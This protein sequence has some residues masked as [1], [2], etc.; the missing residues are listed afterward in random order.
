M[1]KTGERIIPEYDK[2]TLGFLEHINRYEFAKQFV[3]GKNVLDIACGSGYGTYELVN[4]GAKRIV[5]VDISEESITYARNR[6]RH[7]KIEYISGDARKIP[8]EDNQF[9]V[10]VSFET[11]EH[12]KEHDKFLKEIIRVSKKN[13][14]LIISTPNSKVY[15]KGNMFHKKE[16]DL[17]N[18]KCLLK[19]YYKHIYVGS[20]NTSL[21]HHI[22]FS[23]RDN[24]FT[25]SMNIPEKS[26][27][28]IVVASNNA[29]DKIKSLYKTQ[30]AEGNT[31][32]TENDKLKSKLMANNEYIDSMH[33]SRGWK[34]ISNIHNLRIRIP[35]INKL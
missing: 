2:N 20:Q 29:I 14:I 4:A 17:K 34:L 12:F 11:I 35:I 6:Y 9:D 30:L 27:Y 33:N 26:A 32:I 13:S 8:L 1:K 5:G 19:K 24:T 7:N 21:V 18:F 3:K 10:I 16:L 22:S 31:I 15:E 28:L 25:E 23:T